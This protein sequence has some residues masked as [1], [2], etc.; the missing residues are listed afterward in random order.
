MPRAIK[1]RP[2]TAKT[3][4][5]RTAPSWRQLGTMAGVLA[6]TLFMGGLAGAHLALSTASTDLM[7]V[8]RT[9]SEPGVS[10]IM[11][12]IEPDEPD[13][14]AM[15]HI[16]EEPLASA[17]DEAAAEAEVVLASLPAPD[18]PKLIPARRPPLWQRYAVPVSVR[19][20]QPMIAIVLDD[21]GLSRA[22]ARRAIALPAPLTLS[23][24]TYAKDL[25]RYTAEARAAGHEL[26][27]HVP[28]E[29]TNAAYDAGPK[30][31]R[32]DMSKDEIA[33]R[34]EWGFNRFEG[35]V[36]I[37]NHMGSKF[38][39]ASGGVSQVMRALRARDLLFLDSV[40]SGSSLAWR[41]AVSSGV[42][43]ARRDIFLDHDWR[44]AD[45]IE[46]QLVALERIARRR[47]Y[48]V[49]IGHPH[50][51]TLD[52]LAKWLPEARRRGIALV[53]ISAIVTQ[54]IKLA[55]G[56]AGTAG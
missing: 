44:N 9:A 14:A 26:M 52:I 13:E 30:V 12:A 45:S 43:V 20:G 50:R 4:S 21:V 22:M 23:F 51:L 55:Q 41:A 19:A 16:Y 24:M 32:N 29:P 27:L 5:A 47:G 34:L 42:P 49:G 48:A 53:P 6:L 40:T 18:I 37:N 36:G 38:T 15:A 31:L 46:D 3:K 7:P 25:R 2:K 1:K 54:Q 56:A 28:M 35:Y 10:S 8:S 39:A 17:L 33:R 11:L